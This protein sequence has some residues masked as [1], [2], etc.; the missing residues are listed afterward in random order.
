MARPLRVEFEE[1]IYHLC[2]RGNA[3]QAIFRDDPDRA[4]FVEMLER[5]AQRFDV[6][7]FCFV[8]MGNHVHL[9][10]QTRSMQSEP[11]DALADG[12]LHGG[13]ENWGSLGSQL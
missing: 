1:A 6:A 7:I 8:L 10:A 2:G 5:S 12:C 11:V 4:R 3:R 9:L 13:R